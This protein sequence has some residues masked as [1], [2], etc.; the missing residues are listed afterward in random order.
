MNNKREACRVL[1]ISYHTLQAY[2]RYPT[3]DPQWKGLTGPPSQETPESACLDVP[4][5]AM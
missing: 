4:E 2:L 1:G 3:A 5:Q